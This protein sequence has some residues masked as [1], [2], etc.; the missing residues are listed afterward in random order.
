MVEREQALTEIPVV[1]PAKPE[2]RGR[3]RFW[4]FVLGFLLGAAA[5]FALALFAA[6]KNL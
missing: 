3:S 4:T 1:E 2:K 5:L 6:L